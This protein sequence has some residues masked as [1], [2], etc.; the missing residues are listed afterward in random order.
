VKKSIF[1]SILVIIVLMSSCVSSGPAKET[2]GMII[3]DGKD[4]ELV[5]DDSMFYEDYE[6]RYCVGHWKSPND[7]IIWDFEVAKAGDYKVYIRVA[8]ADGQSGSTVGVTVNGQELTFEM[9][10]TYQWETWMDLDIGNVS[11]E[12]GAQTLIV[13]GKELT[14]TYYGNLKSVSLIAQ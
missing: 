6:G 9:P 8:C 3:L 10:D 13:Q 12:E 1:L 14:K 7:Q 11:L 4:A 5:T 2:P